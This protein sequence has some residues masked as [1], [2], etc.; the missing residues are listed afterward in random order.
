MVKIEVAEYRDPRQTAVRFWVAGALFFLCAQ[1]A[2]AVVR[3][4]R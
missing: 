3:L 1:I 2:K 4:K